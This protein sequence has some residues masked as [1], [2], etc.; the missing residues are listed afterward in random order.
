MKLLTIIIALLPLTI[1]CQEIEHICPPNTELKVDTFPEYTVYQCIANDVQ[2]GTSKAYNNEGILKF[3]NHWKKGKAVGIWKEWDKK[4]NLWSTTVYENGAKNG[5]EI[6]YYNNGNKKV[7]TTFQNGIK[8]GI[9]NQWNEFGVHLI[10]GNFEM[11]L[12]DGLWFIRKNETKIVATQFQNGQQL[13]EQE[14][15]W[16]DKDLPIVIY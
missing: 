10:T 11:G 8:H 7:E 4:G 14:Q 2:E 13:F 3:E 5:L 16:T 9:I 6:F 15:D 12:E 1:F